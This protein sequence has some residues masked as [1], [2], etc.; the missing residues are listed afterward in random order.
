MPPEWLTKKALAGDEELRKLQLR[1]MGDDIWMRRIA[2]GLVVV[3]VIVA[4]V[5]FV[6]QPIPRATK[7]F[8]CLTLLGPLLTY[9]FASRRR[10]S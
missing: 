4:V 1:W 5:S 6:L 9:F 7:V 10:R 2:F 8:G 3:V